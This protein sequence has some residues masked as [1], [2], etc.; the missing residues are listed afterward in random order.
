MF[1]EVKLELESRGIDYE[2]K[3]ALPFKGGYLDHG[4]L[5]CAKGVA[6]YI[7]LTEQARLY[8]LTKNEVMRSA[9]KGQA[10]M[11]FKSMYYK[12]GNERMIQRHMSEKVKGRVK[13][14]YLPCTDEYKLH[15]D[16]GYFVFC[17]VFDNCDAGKVIQ[18]M[19]EEYEIFIRNFF[20]TN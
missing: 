17:S 9:T 12:T 5:F 18:K 3:N 13:V 1:V 11:L 7:E 20:F 6:W 10:Y 4:F 14:I 19:I 15:I 16:S 2:F 8:N